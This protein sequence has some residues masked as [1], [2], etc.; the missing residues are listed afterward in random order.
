MKVRI[1]IAA[2]AVAAVSACA[3]PPSQDVVSRSLTA[4]S[5]SSSVVD[6]Q[7]NALRASRGLSTLKR[8]RA[9]DRAAQMHAADMA[10]RNFF[11]HKGSN[12]STVGRRSK[13]AGYDWCRVAEN[14]AKGQPDT[15]SVMQAWKASSG[16]L[17]NMTIRDM[18][19]YGIARSGPN[20]VMVLG[21][22]SC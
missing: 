14:I 21:A 11:S 19:N 12:G 7:L 10:R 8:S 18:D 6:Q 1:G 22:K 2:L 15:A 16:H 20:W 9:L 17:R 5:F 13:M 4:P 3:A